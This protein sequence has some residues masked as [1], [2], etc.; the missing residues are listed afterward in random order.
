[1]TMLGFYQAF[2]HAGQESPYWQ[3][4]TV[5]SD[6][7][8]VDFLALYSVTA[9]AIQGSPSASSVVTTFKLSYSTD[10]MTWQFVTD[11]DEIEQVHRQVNIL[12]IYC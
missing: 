6:W 10:G 7:I 1:M 4:A 2:L 5:D 11:S 3:A 8:G 12:V 9:L